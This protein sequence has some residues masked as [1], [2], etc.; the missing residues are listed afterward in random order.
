MS[1]EENKDVVRRTY[2]ELNNV[3]GDLNRHR[4]YFKK[5]YAPGLVIH[6]PNGDMTEGQNEQRVSLLYSAFSDIKFSIEDMIAEEDKVATRYVFSCVH[7]GPFMGKNPSGKPIT[8]RGVNIYR[9]GGGQIT[10][11]WE[12]MDTFGLLMQVGLIP[13]PSSNK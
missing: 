3:E 5:C 6:N 12:M 8:V 4:A 10:E 7:S 11:V 2:D 1:I 13:N 9:I